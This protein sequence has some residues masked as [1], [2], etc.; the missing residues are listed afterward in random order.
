M[1]Y[2]IVCEHKFDTKERVPK[3]KSEFA[4]QLFDP[5]FVVA[6]KGW[7]HG[8]ACLYLVHPKSGDHFAQWFQLPLPTQ[9]RA[10]L[11]LV[12]AG[13]S[14]QND[15]Q[16]RSPSF[17]SLDLFRTIVSLFTNSLSAWVALFASFLLWLD[18]RPR[19]VSLP[20]TCGRLAS[21]TGLTH[22]K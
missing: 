12:W 3:Q 10:P 21:K 13:F 7:V 17:F 22:R 11:F 5:A 4:T 20:P 1:P 6:E 16:R 19:L 15:Q 2:S 9:L 14:Y 18:A 8:P